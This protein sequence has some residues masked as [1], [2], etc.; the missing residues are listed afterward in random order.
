[1]LSVKQGGIKYH[2]F[3]L[4]CESTSDLTP[5]S[6]AIG[7]HSDRS[8]KRDETVNHISECSEMSQKKCNSR[9]D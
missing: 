6:R 1:M 2:S 5:V 7:V 8:D 9:H 3:S 4:W